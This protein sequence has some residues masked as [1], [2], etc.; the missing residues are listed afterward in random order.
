MSGDAPVA[1]PAYGCYDLAT[2]AVGSGSR[3]RLYDLDPATLAPD[4]ESLRAAVSAGVSAVVVVHF[5]G[6][7]VDLAP[8][9]EVLS[10][11]LVIEDAAQGAGARLRGRPLGSSGSLGVLSFGRAKGVTCGRGGALLAND[12]AGQA[13]LDGWDETSRTPAG[14][15]DVAVAAALAWL[16]RPSIY[17]AP[18][19]LPF[20]HLGE[21]VYKPPAS[22]RPASRA[23][24]A[25][26]AHTWPLVEGEAT[27]RRENADRLLRVARSGNAFAAVPVPAG[28]RPGYLR[29]P[30]LVRRQSIRSA[31][32]RPA[33]RLGIAAGYP[34]PLSTLEPLAVCCENADENF[35]GARHLCE[36]VLTLP[37]HGLLGEGDLELLERW[38][39]MGSHDV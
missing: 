30:L 37:V 12:D 39:A 23:A 26:L 18:A 22:P 21:T 27:V 29:L 25:L 36:H 19:L 14:W 10:G 34:R 31:G 2:A 11:T 9:D 7:P 32:L 4:M 15:S 16:S 13:I 17:W 3:V 24:R 5:Y 28:A 38:I 20:L 35:H 8:L 1:L 6:I 33:R